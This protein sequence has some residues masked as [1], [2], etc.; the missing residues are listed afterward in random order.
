MCRFV[1]YQG[2]NALSLS[3]LL[4]EPEHALV[5]QALA[6]RELNPNQPS[7]DGWGMIWYPEGRSAPAGYHTVLPMW[8]DDNLQTLTPSLAARTFM[9]ATRVAT[10]SAE[11]SITNVQPFTHG[12]LS[13]CHNGELESFEKAFLG[14]IRARLSGDTQALPRGVTDSAHLFALWIEAMRVS[15]DISAAADELVEQ[16]SRLCQQVARGAILNLLLGDAEEAVAIRYATAGQKHASLYWAE[17][18]EGIVVAS[19]PMSEANWHA[20]A[21]NTRLTFRGGQLRDERA[22]RI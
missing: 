12:R 21:P 7:A 20:V 19:E 2:P 6:P 11:L 4:E 16:V 10:G 3:R 17:L 9:A 15:P 8:R 13:F 14:P 5:E 22:L 1:L 18:F